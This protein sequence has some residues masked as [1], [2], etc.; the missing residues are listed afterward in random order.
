MMEAATSLGLCRIGT[1][2]T[3]KCVVKSVICVMEN[4]DALQKAIQNRI[5]FLETLAPDAG[6]MEELSPDVEMERHV[7][8]LC[9]EFSRD[10]V[11]GID[12][13]VANAENIARLSD[14]ALAILEQHNFFGFLAGCLC[15]YAYT[16]EQVKGLFSE[17]AKIGGQAAVQLLCS[18]CFEFFRKKVWSTGTSSSLLWK[19]TSFDILLTWAAS[20][21]TARSCLISQP[22]LAI[23]VMRE[24]IRSRANSSLNLKA[25]SLVAWLTECEDAIEYKVE[26]K[27]I[28]MFIVHNWNLYRTG[29]TSKIFVFIGNQF[30]I[31]QPEFAEQSFIQDFKLFMK[32]DRDTDIVDRE[33]V[34]NLL[35]FLCLR[36][37]YALECA[38]FFDSDIVQFIESLPKEE[39]SEVDKF[40]LYRIFI[41][42]IHEMPAL[43]MDS[44]IGHGILHEA[45][46]I[47]NVGLLH[48]KESVLEFVAAL[49]AKHP[50]TAS[51]DHVRE[52]WTSCLESL[53]T[54]APENL[55]SLIYS[56]LSLLRFE[57]TAGNSSFRDY[58]AAHD[59]RERVQ[60]LS[61]TIDDENVSEV[62]HE[63]L[64]ALD[65]PM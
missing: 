48:A 41:S 21:D 55:D 15:K 20:T 47:M 18:G 5:R 27:E 52:I 38:S 50:A 60:S 1:R 37:Q 51:Q 33:V 16:L 19:E 40:A 29:T 53:E 64:A 26:V 22:N 11:K 62:S 2:V 6:C 8:S 36:C 9:A 3:N 31:T 63:L 12:S 46:Q 7:M 54:W 17:I 30:A 25:I 45:L 57:D 42:Q 32:G 56:A 44:A 39:V 24:F 59:I 10:P 65:P 35:K 13:L 34:T 43:I 23:P 14:N 58:L 28:M 61:D 49:V 4:G